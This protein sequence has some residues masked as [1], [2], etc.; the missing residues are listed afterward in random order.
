MPYSRRNFVKTASVIAL[1]ATLPLEAIASLRRRVSPNDKIQVGL[2][3]ANNQ[4]FT[5]LKSFLLNSEVEC[6]AIADVDENVYNRRA[7]ELVQANFKKPAF[8]QDYRKMLKD[9][10]IDVVIIGTPDHWHCLMLV[11]T[12]EA[13]KDAYLEKPIGN[14]IYEIDIMA[15]AVKKQQRLVQVGQWQ[16]SQPHFVDAINF[17]HSGQLG[18]IRTTKTWSYVDWKG[19]VPKVPDAPVPA[20][21]DYNMWLGPAPRRPFN[22]NRFHA[23]WRW[24]WEYGGGVMTDWGVHL[25]DYILYGMKASVPKSV[26]A[27]GGKMAFPD[28]DMVT[29]DTLHTMYDFGNF[30]MQWEQTIGIGR[31][32]YGRPHGISFVGENGTLVLDRNGWEV[33][34][35]KQKM[36]AVSYKKGDSEVGLDLHVRNFLDCVTN[37]TPE[38]LNANLEIGRNVALVSQ[39]GNIA[40]RTGERVYWDAAKQK[41]TSSAANDLI[42]P[43]YHNG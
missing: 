36:E 17:V 18:H 9:K 32:F 38:K 15:N 1:G 28:D 7:E 34:P 19:A 37:K 40:Y 35:E 16:R 2:I 26:M 24:Y 27:M 29:P 20:G 10:D 25:I 14:S 41:F 39:M 8:Y 23:S 31:G 12:L 5:N 43:V 33:L 42:K 3:G 30:T 4:G 21:V 11:D 6:V 13:G 22:K